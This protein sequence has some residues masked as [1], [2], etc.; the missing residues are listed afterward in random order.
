MLQMPRKVKFRKAQK[1]KNRG[2]A[3]RGDKL[4]FGEYGL[5]A[6]ENGIMKSNHMEASRLVIVRKM[7]GAGKLW[8][9]VF[10]HKPVTKKPAETRMGKGKGDLSH[11]VF[12]VKRGKVILELGGIPE[13]FAKRIFRLVAFKLPFKTKFVTRAHH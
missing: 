1:G 11:W 8:V 3:T 2:V 10:P 13:D 5:K 9:K 12:P 6:L 4:T 7:K